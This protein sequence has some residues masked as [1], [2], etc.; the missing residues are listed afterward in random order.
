MA[1]STGHLGAARGLSN[2]IIHMRI[3]RINMNQF[4]LVIVTQR[5]QPPQW[6][7]GEGWVV[8]MGE[9]EGNFATRFLF[10]SIRSY[11]LPLPPLP[12][13]LP[14]FRFKRDEEEEEEEEE[15]REEEEGGGWKGFL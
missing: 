10:T 15:E 12:L 14:F 13:Y 7:K 1:F 4:E 8:W 6:K 9:E 5:L 11:K 3:I 2:P